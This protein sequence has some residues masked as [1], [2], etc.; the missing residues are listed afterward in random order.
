[1]ISVNQ[2]LSF[3]TVSLNFVWARKFKRL[4]VDIATVC[5]FRSIKSTRLHKGWLPDVFWC[6]VCFVRW[7][8]KNK[9]TNNQDGFKS[10]LFGTI[11]SIFLNS[12]SKSTITDVVCILELGNIAIIWP[13]VTAKRWLVYICLR[14]QGKK[15]WKAG[16]G[17][18]FLIHTSFE[19]I[20]FMADSE[21]SKWP[22]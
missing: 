18:L 8:A 16:L 13:W 19:I 5:S 11:Y 6:W 7:L 22:L 10:S 1:M 15:K 4:L 17:M 2:F 3:P 20:L 9:R 14:S 12:L 21:N